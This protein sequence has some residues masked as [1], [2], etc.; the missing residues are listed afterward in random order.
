MRR[1]KI[2]ALTMQLRSQSVSPMAFMQVVE[3]NDAKSATE[4]DGKK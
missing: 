2:L 1:S 4:A 3:T